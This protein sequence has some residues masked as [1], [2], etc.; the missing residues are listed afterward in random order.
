MKKS[1]VILS[2]ALIL[3]VS[4]GIVSAGVVGD[5]WGKSVITGKAATTTLP[6][7]STNLSNMTVLYAKP[8]YCRVKCLR[9][10]GCEGISDAYLVYNGDNGH[11]LVMREYYCNDDSWGRIIIKDLGMRQEGIG[12]GGG[13]SGGSGSGLGSGS[14]T[15]CPQ[16][17]T[18]SGSMLGGGINCVPIPSST[19]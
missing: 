18:Q 12:G 3:I 7:S 1:L 2:F 9:R 4:L 8:I 14:S 13:S 6:Y 10:R 19:R 15:T 17:Y 11:Q 5:L 16:G